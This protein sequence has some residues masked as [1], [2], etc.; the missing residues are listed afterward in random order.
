MAQ[1]TL[2][3]SKCKFSN[4]QG[5]EHIYIYVLTLP[6]ANLLLITHQS[7][8]ESWGSSFIDLGGLVLRLGSNLLSSIQR[9]SNNEAH[10]TFKSLYTFCTKCIQA[11]VLNVSQ[12][13]PEGQFSWSC[14]QMSI[15][16]QCV[17]IST[18]VFAYMPPKWNWLTYLLTYSSTWP[19][20]LG[21]M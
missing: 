14:L 7:Y 11:L 16:L 12:C 20:F 5:K 4:S 18:I 6:V 2:I 1:Y 13:G 21:E 19:P 15:D 9:I 10:N 17:G 8:Y 3:F